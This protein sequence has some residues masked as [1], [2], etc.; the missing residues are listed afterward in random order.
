MSCSD[1]VHDSTVVF[2]MSMLLDI[3]WAYTVI[4]GASVA[5]GSK[6]EVTYG[7]VQPPLLVDGRMCIEYPR[8]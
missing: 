2:S 5:S 1:F 6:Y 3:Y 8:V 4:F 7:Q